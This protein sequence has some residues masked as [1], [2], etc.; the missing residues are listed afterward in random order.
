MGAIC[1]YNQTGL[2][3]YKEQCQ[4]IHDNQ[5][6]DN[7]SDCKKDNCTKRHTKVCKT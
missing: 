2:G 7:G 4:T 6:R 3:K 5:L 1:K